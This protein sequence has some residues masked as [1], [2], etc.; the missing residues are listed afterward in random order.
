MI[1]SFH[2]AF[3]Y[4]PSVK[5]AMKFA[6]DT[7]IIFVFDRAHKPIIRSQQIASINM[8]M[9][10][11]G[12]WRKIA[13][14]WQFKLA[15]ISTTVERDFHLITK[16]HQSSSQPHYNLEDD[17]IFFPGSGLS[18]MLRNVGSME[19]L[20]TLGLLTTILVPLAPTLGKVQDP[21]ALSLSRQ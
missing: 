1:W 3:A 8:N 7:P 9:S 21:W 14:N 10:M 2:W 6:W 16:G 17:D 5:I 13:N 12:F 19:K 18:I 4:T 11:K 20:D 15:G